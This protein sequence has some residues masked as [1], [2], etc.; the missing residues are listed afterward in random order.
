MALAPR[1]AAASVAVEWSRRPYRQR[2]SF[3]MEFTPGPADSGRLAVSL[4]SPQEWR[5]Q[6][7]LH[8]AVQGGTQS[9][10]GR[11]AAGQSLWV[12]IENARGES[13]AST[14]LVYREGALRAAGETPRLALSRQGQAA[15]WEVEQVRLALV[16]ALVCGVALALVLVAIFALPL[17]P[18]LRQLAWVSCLVLVLQGGGALLFR[19]RQFRLRRVLPALCI[20]VTGVLYLVVSLFPHL[21]L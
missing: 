5:P 17:S 8:I 3:R 11:I 13:T 1:Q 2:A 7:A 12:R 14:W 6:V 10:G 19:R 16:S 18:A 20:L 9:C 4:S 15:D 21:P